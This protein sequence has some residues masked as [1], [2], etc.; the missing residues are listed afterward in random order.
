MYKI[1]GADQKE[2][3]PVTAEQIELWLARGRVNALTKAQAEGTEWKS[4]NQFPE[5]AVA[6][7]N[8]VAPRTSAV[9]NLS[10]SST[11][12]RSSGLALAS[13]VLGILG[14]L[15]FGVTAV[16]GL[17]LGIV[18]LVQIG[19]SNGTVTGRGTALTGTIICAIFVVMMPF[20]A[21]RFFPAFARA[22]TRGDARQLAMD[23]II[24]AYTNTNLPAAVAWCDNLKSFG[25]SRTVP[26]LANSNQPC[27]FAFNTNLSG[28]NIG[29][30]NPSTVLLFESDG[31]WNA[32]GGPQQA[33]QQSQHGRKIVVAFVD[34]HVETVGPERLDQLRWKP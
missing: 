20:G 26:F 8:P 31:G 28:M 34:G 9:P 33:L 17:I 15:S 11:Q 3:G 30:I 16:V 23:T 5:F 6:L 4:L 25:S 27:G 7:T 19:R 1:I 14:F 21:A 32:S 22:K 2:Y 12:V 13:L 24:Y 10:T 18:S 29:K